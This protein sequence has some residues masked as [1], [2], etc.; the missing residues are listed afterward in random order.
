MPTLLLR[1]PDTPEQQLITDLSP[2]WGSDSGGPGVRGKSEQGR[3]VFERLGKSEM[4]SGR[5]QGLVK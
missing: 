3:R 1:G 4:A 5:R 2:G